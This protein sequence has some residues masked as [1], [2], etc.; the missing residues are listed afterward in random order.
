MIAEY[1][2]E[3]FSEAFY[4]YNGVLFSWQDVHNF[5]QECKNYEDPVIIIWINERLGGRVELRNGKDQI[6][7]YINRD[8]EQFV[9]YSSFH[10]G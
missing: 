9:F 7:F 8:L 5:I 10:L 3:Q 1:S 2:I 4:S 6:V